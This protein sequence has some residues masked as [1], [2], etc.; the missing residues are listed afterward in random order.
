MAPHLWSQVA[1]C[2]QHCQFGSH[3][4]KDRTPLSGRTRLQGTR[5]IGCPAHI[6]IHELTLFPSFA[7]PIQ[8]GDGTRKIKEL[9]AKQ[10]TK[11]KQSFAMDKEVE[12]TKKYFVLLNSY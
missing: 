6:H 4:F 8:P 5:K 11:L 3:Y 2:K 1:I 10:I 9:R 12:T 7:I